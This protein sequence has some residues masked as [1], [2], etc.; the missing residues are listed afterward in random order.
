[1]K[2]MRESR[3]SYMDRRYALSVLAGFALCPLCETNGFA[4]EDAHWSYSGATGPDRWGKLDPESRLCSTGG[5]QSPLD[6]GTTIKAELPA[7]QIAWLKNAD[8]ILNNGHTIQVNFADGSTAAAGKERL[9]LQQVHFHLPSEHLI[10]G[11]SFPMEAHFVHSKANGGLA[12]IGVLMTMGAANPAFAKIVAAM[13]AKP[14]PVRKIDPSLDPNGLL[15]AARGYFRYAGSLTTPP[16]SEIVDWLLLTDT[17]EV[18]DSDIAAFS[19]IYPMNARPAQMD[20]RRY[21]LRSS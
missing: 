6:I 3:R 17:I 1:M 7:L 18:A 14:G 9:M 11:R 8:T 20:N 19:R 15:P 4:A 12:V 13:P 2:D 21:V 10:G 16:C 5:Q